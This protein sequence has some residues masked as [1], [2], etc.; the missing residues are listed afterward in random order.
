MNRPQID[1]LDS[2]VTKTTPRNGTAAISR[3]AVLHGSTGALSLGLLRGFKPAS[4]QQDTSG[5]IF[6]HGIASGDPLQDRVIIWTRAVPADGRARKVSVTWQVSTSPDFE[7]ITSTEEARTGPKSD[8]TVKVDAGGLEPD[9]T[10]YYRFFAEGVDSATGRTHTLPA[11][12][13]DPVKLAVVSCS[14][15]PQGFFHV[16]AELAKRDYAAVLHLG[17]YIYEYPEGVYSNDLMTK[18]FGRSVAPKGE[19]IALE[20]YRMRY[21]L[22]RSDPDLQAVHAAHPFICVWDDHE[23]A[24]DTW[25]TGAENHNSDE[26]P[27]ET[28]RQAAL[29]AY[30]EWLPIRDNTAG[31]Q[32]IIYRSF[33]IGDLASIIMLDTRLV[34]R[35]QPLT[36]GKDLPLRTLPF[37]MLPDT[38]PLAITDPAELKKLRASEE[39]RDQIQDIPVPFRLTSTGADP[40]LDWSEIQALDPKKLP[41]GI[42]YL[43]DL[44][45]FKTDI[46]PAK[47]RSMLG[48]KQQNW[49]GQE[50]S[51]SAQDGKPWQI[52]GQQVLTGKVGIPVISDEDI[53]QD[54]SSYVTPRQ[55]AE[56]RALAAMDLPLNLDAWD[57]YPL[58]REALFDSI[59]TEA[60][61]AVLLAG[62][63]H[64]AWAFNLADDNGNAVAVEF[65]TAGVSSPGM[66]EY[67][68]VK[69]EIVAN[70]IKAKS[71]ELRFLNSHR[72]GWVELHISE[73]EVEA[74]FE[75]VST[76]RDEN[77]LLE[78]PVKKRVK[79]GAHKMEES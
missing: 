48:A 62:D 45:K 71:P 38:Q 32:S 6:T 59:Q 29:Q 1:R 49:F 17:D 4:A 42:S 24:N 9:Q 47:G 78:P 72:R 2:D 61:N 56:F 43:P 55:L 50:L 34:G 46:L 35:D 64:N 25:K 54:S 7:Y 36:Y 13:L 33:Q 66:E 37:R 10:Y 40:I 60:N 3:R 58:A 15:Y 31:D 74:S 73:T 44:E 27:F 21:G 75:F 12:G 53:D 68:P 20:D 52:V 11:A 16:Y 79:V 65:A 69:P 70:A 28:R 63:T 22:Y 19:V 18:E 57:G 67:L 5:T 14:N 8:Y 39:T 76:V 23:I 41:K 30:H 51:K 26:G 77:Y